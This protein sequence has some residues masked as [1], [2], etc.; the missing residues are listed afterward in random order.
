MIN[1]VNFD[2]KRF[3]FLTLLLLTILRNRMLITWGAEKTARC[4][5]NAKKQHLKLLKQ[6]KNVS[7]VNKTMW[8]PNWKW[9]ELYKDDF[10]VVLLWWIQRF[11]VSFTSRSSVQIQPNQ[12]LSIIQQA[13]QPFQ[14]Y[15]LSLCCFEPRPSILFMLRLAHLWFPRDWLPVKRCSLETIRH[16]GGILGLFA[17]AWKSRRELC[18]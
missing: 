9:T 1:S 4:C 10:S 2:C 12:T 8:S 13:L 7:C 5:A 17:L 18:H 14:G 11:N 6:C 3:S 16:W 15:L